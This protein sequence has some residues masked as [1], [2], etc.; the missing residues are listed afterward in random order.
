MVL[1]LVASP[2][3]DFA[4]NITNLCL[5]CNS[6]S[7]KHDI[8]RE[9]I[10]KNFDKKTVIFIDTKLES[11]QFKNLDYAEFI[12]LHEDMPVIDR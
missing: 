7:S 6:D 8:I 12:I 2:D 5:I 10:L 11:S 3:I 4:Q 9:I 1:D